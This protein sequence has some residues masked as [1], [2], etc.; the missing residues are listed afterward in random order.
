MAYI[1]T[2]ITGG[3]NVGQAFTRVNQNLAAIEDN[4]PTGGTS[5]NFVPLT[6]TSLGSEITGDIVITDSNS[7]RVQ[8]NSDVNSLEINI[9]SIDFRDDYNSVK[10][11]LQYS[12]QVQSESLINIF[13]T[14]PDGY[15]VIAPHP[16]G[17]GGNYVRV[18]AGGNGWEYFNLDAK[19]LPLSGGTLTG[20]LYLD[21]NLRFYDPANS[22]YGT[23]F[24]DD[25][26]YT[27]KNGKY[28]TINAVIGNGGLTI[29]DNSTTFGNYLQGNASAN[30][31]QILPDKDGTFA[32]LS[33]ITGATVSGFVRN[34]GDTITGLYTINDGP[35]DGSA[36][37]M[38]GDTP[39]ITLS[40]ATSGTLRI[41]G[42]DIGGKLELSPVN[43]NFNDN[44]NSTMIINPSLGTT[45]T[46]QLTILKLSGNTAGYIPTVE[47]ISTH[48]NEFIRINNN[49]TAFGFGV[50]SG[51]GTVSVTSTVNGW[52]ISGASG[53]SGG[54]V[55]GVTSAGTGN[56]LLLSG[57]VV[58]NRIV[59]KSLLA[60]SGIGITESNGTIT[61]SGSGGSS[62]FTGI[63][64]ASTVGGGV[65]LI[66][67]ITSNNL[68]LNS[69]SGTA[70]MVVNAASN[71][72]VTF[73]GPN[74]AN[75]VF[76]TDAS[77]NMVNADFLFTDNVNDTLGINIAAAT[78]ARLLL[79][80][81]TAAI[82]P[83]RFTKS[84][85]DYTGAVDG[86]LWYLTSG[87]SLK[88]YKNNIATDFIFKDNNNTLTGSSN[89]RIVQADSAGTI[90]ANISIV[91]FGIFNM[92]TSV[93]ITNTTS[94][95]SI[96]N[97]G[98]TALVGTNI[99]NSSVHATAPQ[100]VAGKKFRFTAK[101]ELQ[102]KNSA[103]GT[104]NVKI[105][106]GSTIISTSSAFT[107]SNNINTPNVFT[108]D[109]TFTIRS[110]GASGT[111]IGSGL[112]HSDEIF[113]TGAQDVYALF[114]QGVLTIDTTTDKTFDVTVQFGTADAT[115]TITFNEATL[116][117]LN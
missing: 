44:N 62:S 78:T 90:S 84:A 8:D 70:G 29:I 92:I 10:T 64:T 4:I 98:A 51:A 56:I 42:G 97:T 61:I 117:Y 100:L 11:R 18:N 25:S 50:L 21:T 114:N 47:D 87:N 53:P 82:T 116:E 36:I 89:N 69:I 111:V 91:N 16:A 5:G 88:F 96:L 45:G 76:I 106:L 40:G 77:G 54:G 34:T 71:G 58:N 73:R 99:I 39:L 26:N 115:N 17:E 12:P 22:E 59:Q 55:T 79:S 110:Q 28:D 41:I 32:M 57:T 38:I 19:F 72:L 6:G 65:S 109:T 103:A 83:L 75:R 52:T 14:L 49:G 60:G 63:T 1:F 15:M 85:T 33:D 9:S 67:A 86:S 80:T 81:Q 104:L 37:R 23:I 27:F 112:L 7:L 101:G 48:P 43:F 35:I 31:T 3:Q 13:D 113:H 102:S 2:A 46:S 107:L 94:E 30:R 95:T 105:K 74:T 66:S 68:Q 24:L 20:D 93:T 108:I